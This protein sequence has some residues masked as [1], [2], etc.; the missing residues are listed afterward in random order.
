MWNK[1]PSPFWA[2]ARRLILRTTIYIHLIHF[3]SEA[4]HSP[5]PPAL[6]AYVLRNFEEDSIWLH[7]AAG[8]AIAIWYALWQFASACL[9]SPTLALAIIA[10][11]VDWRWNRRR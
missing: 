11:V 1:E 3:A 10:S 7:G 9:T 4:L 2:A 6:R 8:I 5:I